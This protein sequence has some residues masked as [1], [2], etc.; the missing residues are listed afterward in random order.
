VTGIAFKGGIRPDPVVRHADSALAAAPAALPLHR[1][2]NVLRLLFSQ[3]P[4]NTFR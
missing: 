4:R 1:R 2:A 3:K